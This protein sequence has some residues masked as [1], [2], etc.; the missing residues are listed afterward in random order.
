M[1]VCIQQPYFAPSA[2]YFRLFHAVDMFIYLIDVQ[3][4]PR[5]RVH[6]CELL[7]SEGNRKW[8]TLPI[9]REPRGVNIEN[10]KWADDAEERWEKLCRRFPF[11]PSVV[12]PW[13]FKAGSPEVFLEVSL[14][15]VASFLLQELP[16]IEVSS[17]FKVRGKGQDKIIALCKE[18]G[19]T[20]YVNLP[21][22][23]K[24][25]EAEAFEKEGIAL[26]FLEPWPESPQLS[27]LH[28]L[29]KGYPPG[30][31]SRKIRRLSK[32]EA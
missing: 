31:L 32:L 7:D 4:P 13:S 6:R 1:R 15:H 8:F 18:V 11:V 28:T 10:L 24:L 21:G 19:A 12:H 26:K 20:E 22:G 5:G 17:E 23:R 27:I 25:Y 16:R 14:E 3:F 30:I 29:D 2:S 9:K